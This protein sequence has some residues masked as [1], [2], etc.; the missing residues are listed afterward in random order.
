MP[1]L[2]VLEL[3]QRQG[4]GFDAEIVLDATMQFSPGGGVLGL[5]E[6]DQQEEILALLFLERQDLGDAF[7]HARR[8][9][10]F[11]L[12]DLGQESLRTESHRSAES[13]IGHGMAMGLLFL[14]P[15]LQENPEI[16]IIE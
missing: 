9:I 7:D 5:V 1:F 14:K 16:G 4:L 2:I 3:L 8:Q 15:V 10:G 6:L 12:Q 13:L 11:A